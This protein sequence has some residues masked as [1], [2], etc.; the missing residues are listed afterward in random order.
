MNL[1]YD[2]TLRIL[3]QNDEE[4]YKPGSREHGAAVQLMRRAENIKIQVYNNRNYAYGIWAYREYNAGHKHDKYWIKDYHV[5][6][7]AHKQELNIIIKTLGYS[8]KGLP[9]T[10]RKYWLSE[11]KEE[12]TYG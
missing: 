11:H 4:L 8:R 5:Y 1:L 7:P 6:S 12:Y 2:L 10:G 9:R 3:L